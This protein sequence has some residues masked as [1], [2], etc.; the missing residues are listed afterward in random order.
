MYNDAPR[1]SEDTETTKLRDASVFTFGL[2]VCAGVKEHS[3]VSSR[4]PLPSALSAQAAPAP[5]VAPSK[6]QE[7]TK[8]LMSS[9]SWM[10]NTTP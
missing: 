8:F 1:A 2:D 6:P 3:P 5:S 10:V 4:Q 7:A 9:T